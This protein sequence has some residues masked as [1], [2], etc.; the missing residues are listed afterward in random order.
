MYVSILARK[1]ISLCPNTAGGLVFMVEIYSIFIMKER[2]V[3][4]SED[5]DHST[6]VVVISTSCSY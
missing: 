5:L 4:V 1:S 6:M 2:G 3:P